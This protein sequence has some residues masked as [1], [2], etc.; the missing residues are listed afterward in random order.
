MNIGSRSQVSRHLKLILESVSHAAAVETD[1]GI[2][3]NAKWRESPCWMRGA[4]MN[5][6][7]PEKEQWWVDFE[8]MMLDR[9]KKKHRQ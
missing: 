2:G 4:S 6:T 7:I 9:K 8:D 3:K 5:S 1:F